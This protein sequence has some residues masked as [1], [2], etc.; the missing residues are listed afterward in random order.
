VAASAKA[1]ASKGIRY[2]DAGRMANGQEQRVVGEDNAWRVDQVIMFAELM[3][4]VNYNAPALVYVYFFSHHLKTQTGGM[5]SSLKDV[6]QC[7]WT[8]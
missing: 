4:H 2:S 3:S 8:L 1:P 6:L 5:R 7:T